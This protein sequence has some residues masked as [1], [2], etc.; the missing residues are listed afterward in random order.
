MVLGGPALSWVPGRG[1]G[2]LRLLQHLPTSTPF[3]GSC[4]RTGPSPHTWAP[5]GSF[6]WACAHRD[7]DTAS[8]SFTAPKSD[9]QDPANNAILSVV[10]SHQVWP[11]NYH[12]R[13]PRAL[14]WKSLWGEHLE[15][16][17]GG[18]ESPAG[19]SQMLPSAV[20]KMCALCVY[21]C[22]IHLSCAL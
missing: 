15:P 21:C 11:I 19:P 8:E 16:S 20:G 2:A 7:R 6:G 12:R 13:A 14:A 4:L 10:R 18:K 3:Y 17:T 22:E 9:S 5:S 1:Q